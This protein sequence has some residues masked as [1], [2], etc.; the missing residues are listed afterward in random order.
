MPLVTRKF[1][2]YSVT[3]I[4]GSSLQSGQPGADINCYEGSTRVGLVRFFRDSGFTP[5]NQVHG[6]GTVALY[7]EMSRFADVATLLRYEK[8]LL[9][10]VNSDDGFGYVATGRLEPTG[11]QEGV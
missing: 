7:Y 6:D 5:P 10:A 11:E 2:R 3:Y 4:G 8:P 1:D 9:L